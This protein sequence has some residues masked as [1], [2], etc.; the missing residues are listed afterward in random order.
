MDQSAYVY[1]SLITA[2]LLFLWIRVAEPETNRRYIFL[3]GICTYLAQLAYHWIKQTATPD[4][5]AEVFTD[6]PVM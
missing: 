5:S 6:D 3:G 1:V 4:S 2:V